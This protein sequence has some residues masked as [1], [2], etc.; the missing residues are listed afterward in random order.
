VLWQRGKPS[1]DRALHD[2]IVL[3]FEWIYRI[4]SLSPLKWRQVFG[5]YINLQTFDS[6]KVDV[7]LQPPFTE[8]ILSENHLDQV[9]LWK[10]K[11][12]AGANR[13]PSVSKLNNVG[14]HDLHYDS[15]TILQCPFNV[16]LIVANQFT[17]FIFV[18]YFLLKLTL[19][20]S[21]TIKCIYVAKLFGS[22]FFF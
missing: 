21:E 10:K 20:L 7:P 22:G 9:V 16:T 14:N 11:S 13:N 3:R 15:T 6:F 2:G 5:R 8:M 17:P 12:S 18:L 1:R 4:Y 19:Y